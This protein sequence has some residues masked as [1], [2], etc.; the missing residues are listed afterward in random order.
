M[1]IASDFN[2]S[3]LV[4]RVKSILTKP[5][6][7]WSVID[8]EPATV[9]GLYTGYAMI[10]AAITPVAGF[11]GGQ[12]F[13]HSFFGVTYRP[14]FVGALVGA[15]L[16]YVLALVGIYILAAIV[17]ALAPSFDGQKN[18]IQAMK[19]AVYAYTASWVAGILGLV[20]ALAPLA[21]LGGL[22]SL[23]LLYLG[24]PRVMHAPQTKALGYTAVTVVVAIVITLI[25]GAVVGVLGF[26]AIS[27][28]GGGHLSSSSG[29]DGSAGTLHIG[30]ATVDLDKLNAAAKQMEAAGQQAAASANGE[31]GDSKAVAAIS[32]D[33]LKDYLPSSV[34]GYSRGDVEANSG[35]VAGFSGTNVEAKYAKGDAHMQLSIT[36]LN[37]A[38]GFAALAG[39]FGVET[40]KQTA[41]GYEKMGKVDGRMTTE[42]WNK[43]SK[44]GKY[45][46][47][48]A[49]RFMVEADG[50]GA[51][52]D[53]L[54]A[55]VG[56]VGPNKL[57]KLAKK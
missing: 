52:M 4:D 16:Q 43:D 26:G 5:A 9:G 33:I 15:I 18:Q 28:S 24:L 56:A 31:A 55:A 22:Y 34:S 53:D 11:I 38:G 8:Q 47:L 57:E 42:E 29:S 54:K 51:D 32:A 48:V 19:V 13:G 7:T 50:E 1:T 30:G 49:D 46:V 14:P 45:G 25:I 10:L 41:T 23:Y 12:V 3:G 40:S 27:A 35:G 6:E 37:A 36:D 44:S 21:L 2:K 17:N 39:A 20:P